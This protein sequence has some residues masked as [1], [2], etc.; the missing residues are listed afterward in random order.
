GDGYHAAIDPGID[1]PVECRCCKNLRVGIDMHVVLLTV[2]GKV[3]EPFRNLIAMIGDLHS[4]ID[5]TARVSH[6]L[7]T[8]HKLVFGVVAKSVTHA[9]MPAGHTCSVVPDGI[10]QSLF[11][12]SG[13]LRHREYLHHEVN[14]VHG[15]LIGIDI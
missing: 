1:F 7:S 4:I 14:V 9:S 8:S 2:H 12:F 5:H 3:L 11:L 13:D 15:C 10:Q 6:P